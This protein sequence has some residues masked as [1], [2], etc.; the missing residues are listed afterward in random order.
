MLV[1]F[2][3]KNEDSQMKIKRQTQWIDVRR[4]MIESTLNTCESSQTRH[5]TNS[6]N[7]NGLCSSTRIEMEVFWW[8]EKTQ[9][10]Q[11]RKYE[12]KNQEKR[13]KFAHKTSEIKTNSLLP[14]ETKITLMPKKGKCKQNSVTRVT[15]GELILL[16]NITR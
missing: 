11:Q 10:K 9:K 12:K 3:K 14:C 13:T 15:V 2:R 1:N 16:I 8:N 5:Y 6:Q 4:M 7:V